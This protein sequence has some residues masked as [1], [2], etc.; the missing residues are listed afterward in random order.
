MC[1]KMSWEKLVIYL[2][3]DKTKKRLYF[4]YKIG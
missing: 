2:F 3:D 4:A 1:E